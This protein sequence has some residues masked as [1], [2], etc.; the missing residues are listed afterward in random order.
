MMLASKHPFLAGIAGLLAIANKSA[1][2]NIEL[3][4]MEQGPR[5]FGPV[6]DL[7][8][9][10]AFKAGLKEEQAQKEWYTLVGK[11]GPAAL[12]ML[13][14]ASKAM[15]GKGQFERIKIAEAFGLSPQLVNVADMI[16]GAEPSRA[17]IIAS[18]LAKLE[19]IEAAG[20]A[21]KNPIRLLRSWGLSLFKNVGATQGVIT[22]RNEAFPSLS[23][24][25]GNA[26]WQFLFGDMDKSAKEID[27]AISTVNR[28]QNAAESAVRYDS[29]G[30]ASSVTT[31]NNN[32]SGT[33][34]INQVIY[35]SGNAQE[36]AEKVGDETQD[37]VNRQRVMD[38][39]TTGD[40][41]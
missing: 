8:R 5:A 41:Q 31:N 29:Q 22:E 14:A 3:A 20:Y 28:A 16:E 26:I 40:K 32:T 10:M 27:D 34:T 6:N 19:K 17:G 15:A 39:I 9:G 12:Q 36:I 37:A 21:S 33:V 11:Y 4:S 13:S 35:A 24:G 18:N 38:A 23:G 30:S 1:H 25:L 2:A 7:F